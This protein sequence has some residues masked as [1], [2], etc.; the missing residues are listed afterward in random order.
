M[1]AKCVINELY[2]EII[3]TWHLGFVKAIWGFCHPQPEPSARCQGPVA[4]LPV[5]RAF[6]KGLPW[7]RIVLLGVGRLKDYSLMLLLLLN[8]KV[9]SSSPAYFWVKVHLGRETSVYTPSQAQGRRE[10][11][12]GCRPCKNLEGSTISACW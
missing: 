7:P 5:D 10:L 9:L 8:K 1:F 6:T 4:G 11:V 12:P 3:T 2:V